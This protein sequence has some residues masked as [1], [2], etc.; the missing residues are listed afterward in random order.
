MEAEKANFPVRTMA[1]LLEVSRSG[2]YEWLRRGEPADPWLQAK[3]DVE[4]E[5]LESDRRFGA[6][7]IQSRL[8]HLTLYRVRKIMRGLGICGVTPNARKR[9]R[10]L[11]MENAFLKKAAAF[12]AKDQA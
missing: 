8:P 7:F 9:I 1:R 3:A 4:R 11:E 10:E 12:F 2:F 6:R 5:W